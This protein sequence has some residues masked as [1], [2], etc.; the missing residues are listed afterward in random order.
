MRRWAQ[1]APASQEADDPHPATNWT[2]AK[3]WQWHTADVAI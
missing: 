3:L 2:L 1:P